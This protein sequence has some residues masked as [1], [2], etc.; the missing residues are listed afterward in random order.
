MEKS[1]FFAEARPDSIGSLAGIRV[2]DF[3]TS[4]SG[5]MACCVL[6]DPGADVI[7]VEAP[8]GEVT[9]RL[10]PDPPGTNLGYADVGHRRLVPWMSPT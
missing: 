10:P 8:G 7:K 6:A 3:S 1:V 4:W 9:R 5:P 2:V